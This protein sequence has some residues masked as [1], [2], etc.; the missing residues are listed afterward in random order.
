MI[1]AARK[2]GGCNPH[3][4]QKSQLYILSTLC[5]KCEYAQGDRNNLQILRTGR[6]G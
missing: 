2:S 1:P 6:E 3:Q 4:K 5:R